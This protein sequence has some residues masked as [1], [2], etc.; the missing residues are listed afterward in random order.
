MKSSWTKRSAA[1]Q[2][3]KK[4]YEIFRLQFDCYCLSHFTDIAASLSNSFLLLKRL[5]MF[6]GAKAKWT[7]EKY[8]QIRYKIH[9]ECF[10]FHQT[11]YTNHIKILAFYFSFCLFPTSSM[12]R[13]G[14]WF[15]VMH[16]EWGKGSKKKECEWLWR[17]WESSNNVYAAHTLTRELQVME[18]R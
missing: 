16:S 10:L 15:K 7:A 8:F 5:H 13:R 18:E 12:E 4:E 11:G 3:K 2:M 6:G 1:D 17:L 9:L 14:K